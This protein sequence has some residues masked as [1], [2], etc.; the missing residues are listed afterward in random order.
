MTVKINKMF[1]LFVLILS[2]VLVSIFAV[3]TYNS[4]ASILIDGIEYSTVLEDLQSDSSFNIESYPLNEKDYSLQVIQIAE[5]ENKELFVYAYQ[6]SGEIGNLTATSINISTGIEENLSYKNY[7]LSLLNSSGTLYKYKVEDF[8]V[9]DDALRYYDIS[10]IFREWNSDFDTDVPDYTG[11]NIDEVSFGVSKLYTA[12]T[13]DG[14]V[15]YNCTGTET[16]VVTDKFVGFIR[17]TNGFPLY[18]VGACDS[19]YIAFS[20]D[21]PIDKLLEADV[22]YVSQTFKTKGSTGGG[23]ILS[24]DDEVSTMASD[25]YEYGEEVE[26]YV[27]LTYDEK[28]EVSPGLIFQHKYEWQRIES[29]EE[30]KQGLEDDGIELTDDTI[31][32]LNNKQWVLRFAETS[33][34]FKTITGTFPSISESGTKVND[35]TILRLKFETNGVVYNLGV[36]DNKQTGSPAPTNKQEDWLKKLLT[37]I[38]IVLLIILLFPILPSI[39]SFAWSVICFPFK[40]IKSIFKKKDKK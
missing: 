10:S 32:S 11:N 8:V 1:L 16:I 37:I 23:M 34:S 21:L 4:Y 29:V 5:S 3:P 7:K 12:C 13:V 17:Y 40:L 19:H 6:P 2:A 9:K 22:Y 39:L 25:N 26:N 36:V 38:L 27:T 15:Y 31:T 35:V 24:V 28:V 33:Y 18:T 30:F 14:E 20:T